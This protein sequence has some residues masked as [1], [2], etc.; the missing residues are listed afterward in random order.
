MVTMHR[1]DN[2]ESFSHEPLLHDL[3]EICYGVR[4][5]CPCMHTVCRLDEAIAAN[6]VL[7]GVVFA[8]FDTNTLNDEE[9]EHRTANSSRTTLLFFVSFSSKYTKPRDGRSVTTQNRL[10]C[11]YH[12]E[13]QSSVIRTIIC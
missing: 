6:R 8:Q 12:L 13:Q 2:A 7:D 1:A 3:R 10:D 5:H 11:V 4:L 9:T